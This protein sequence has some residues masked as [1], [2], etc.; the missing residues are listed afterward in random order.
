MCLAFQPPQKSAW[1]KA[2][3]WLTNEIWHTTLMVTIVKGE[4]DG[5]GIM[6]MPKAIRKEHFPESTDFMG[7]IVTKEDIED[8]LK[9]GQF[10]GGKKG[11]LFWD[12]TKRA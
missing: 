6:H 4:K 10:D 9:G 12:V 11:V 3:R 8:A 5:T 1:E 2:Q 7:K